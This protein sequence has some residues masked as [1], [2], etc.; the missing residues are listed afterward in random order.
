[1]DWRNTAGLN[2]EAAAVVV[3]AWTCTETS[4]LWKSIFWLVFVLIVSFFLT[5]NDSWTEEIF[6]NWNELVLILVKL[7]Q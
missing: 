5:Q 2:V 3:C 6:E 7:Y 4:A 1:M